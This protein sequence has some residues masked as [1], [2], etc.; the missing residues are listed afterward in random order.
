[1]AEFTARPGCEEE[2]ER[3]LLAFTGEVRQ[4]PGCLDFTPHRVEA[5]S[6]G[7][8]GVAEPV[9]AG[10]RFIV[11]EVYRDSEAF[12]AHLAARHGAAFNS[13]LAPLIEEPASM[14]TF[15]RSIA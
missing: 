13:A 10:S 14:L 7:R 15:L 11:S 2:V 6:V 1:M 4:E 8:P 3:L 9:A 5:P 12:A